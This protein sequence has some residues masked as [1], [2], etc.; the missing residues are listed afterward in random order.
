LGQT[1]ALNVTKLLDRY[2]AV[3]HLLRK[4]MLA[5]LNAFL[6]EHG[7][8]AGVY[9]SCPVPKGSLNSVM[10][11]V[12]TD[13][14][15]ASGPPVCEEADDLVQSLQRSMM[16]F[17]MVRSHPGSLIRNHWVAVSQ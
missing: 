7:F 14:H 3:E 17:R 13:M 10:A 6:K 8:N 4:Y 9:F 12:S 11:A 16:F 2:A 1:G 5:D 15:L